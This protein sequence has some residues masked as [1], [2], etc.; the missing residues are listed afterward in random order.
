ME[1][2]AGWCAA[3]RGKVPHVPCKAEPWV[4]MGA[5][6]PVNRRHR[7]TGVGGGRVLT[8]YLLGVF[9]RPLQSHSQFRP[10]QPSSY[11][12]FPNHLFMSRPTWRMHVSL[13]ESRPPIRVV[14]GP[15]KVSEMWL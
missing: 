12:C 2:Q 5:E 4:R 11:S 15:V 10:T 13:R 3:R 14:I 8:A 7:D 9:Y 6:G 1:T